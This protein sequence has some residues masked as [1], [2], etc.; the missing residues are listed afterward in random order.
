MKQFQATHNSTKAEQQEN[1]KTT[2]ERATKTPVDT[3]SQ[4]LTSKILVSF[5]LTIRHFIIII[6]WMLCRSMLGVA[7]YLTMHFSHYYPPNEHF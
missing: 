1:K 6:I 7:F 4:A 5:S 3:I 2:R